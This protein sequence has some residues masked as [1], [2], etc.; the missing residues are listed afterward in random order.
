MRKQILLLKTKDKEIIY[1][2]LLQDIS[3]FLNV[4]LIRNFEKFWMLNLGIVY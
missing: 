1:R 4:N 2:I 3:V